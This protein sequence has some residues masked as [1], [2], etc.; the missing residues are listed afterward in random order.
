MALDAPAL[1]RERERV[2]VSLDRDVVLGAAA[3]L[4]L[5][6]VEALLAVVRPHLEAVFGNRLARRRCSWSC[7]ASSRRTGLRSLKSPL[8]PACAA[9]YLD[10]DLGYGFTKTGSQRTRRHT[11]MIASAFPNPSTR[12]SVLP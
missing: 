9:G 12:G 3:E 11:T 5:E 6:Q 1:E 10:E 8:S 7:C 4:A 2:G